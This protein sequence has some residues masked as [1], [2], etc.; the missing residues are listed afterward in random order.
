MM[1]F[2]PGSCCRNSKSLRVSVKTH[3]PADVAC[4]DNGILGLYELAPVGLQPFHIAVPAGENI[5]RLGAAQ[6]KV[7]IAKHKKCHSL[8]TPVLVYVKPERPIANYEI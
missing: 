8:F 7:G 2:W 3:G 4:K 1:S 5:H 6:G